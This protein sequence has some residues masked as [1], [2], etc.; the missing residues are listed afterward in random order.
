MLLNFADK[1]QVCVLT[2]VAY[3]RTC[4]LLYICIYNNTRT[5]THTHIYMCTP[6]MT[7]ESGRNM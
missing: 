6:K 2:K 1:Y 7:H 5:H 3:I 4:I